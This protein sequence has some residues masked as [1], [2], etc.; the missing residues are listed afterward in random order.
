MRRSANRQEAF[1]GPTPAGSYAARRIADR[2]TDG[3]TAPRT[4][5]VWRAA[6]PRPDRRSCVGRQARLRAGRPRPAAPDA[7]ARHAL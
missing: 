4:V 2:A 3:R 5:R 1:C 7:A 6:S